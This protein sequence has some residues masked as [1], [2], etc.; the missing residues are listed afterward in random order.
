M[1][2]AWAAIT[3]ATLVLWGATLTTVSAAPNEDSNVS[4]GIGVVCNTSEQMHRL[5]GL[6]MDGAEIP[7]AVKVVNSE[8]K[9]PRA[10]GV[11]AVAFMS[12]KMIDIQAVRG[13]M[14]QIV[15]ISV[16]A[17]YDGQHWARVPAMTQYA[18]IEPE[19]YAI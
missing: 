12:D 5:V 9:D 13:K 10:C 7:R 11:A 14:V 3:V 4:I 2:Y 15:R 19:G 16:V 8:A 1:R 6:R 17:A 18:L